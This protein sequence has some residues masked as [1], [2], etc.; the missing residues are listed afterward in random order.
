MGS[1]G[2]LTGTI[3][4]QVTQA[5]R[6]WMRTRSSIG[7][8]CSFR[9]LCWINNGR[10]SRN[11]VVRAAWDG[12]LTLQYGDDMWNKSM[13]SSFRNGYE[14]YV[15]QSAA[16]MNMK[17]PRVARTRDKYSWSC[18]S[19]TR[20]NELNERAW[21]GLELI[22]CSRVSLIDALSTRHTETISDQWM[23]D[24]FLLLV[25]WIMYSTITI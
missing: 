20:T 24:S 14:L 19:S 2:P 23:F 7:S 9:H 6:N 3:P 8:P 18:H 4:V 15:L 22:C 16:S 1:G 10:S 17:S 21:G 13:H 11:K 5:E 12:Y 25:T